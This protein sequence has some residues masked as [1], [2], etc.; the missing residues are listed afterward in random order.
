MKKNIVIITVLGC[1]FA[2]LM[3]VGGPGQRGG[4]SGA[5]RSA[6]PQHMAPPA[7]SAPPQHIAPRAPPQHIAPR[8]PPQHVAPRAPQ[9]HIAPRAAPRQAQNFSRSPSLSRS[10]PPPAHRTF[11]PQTQRPPA[12]I[13]PHNVQARQDIRNNFQQRNQPLSNLPSSLQPPV[14]FPTST[15]Q[16]RQ[17]ISRQADGARSQ[18]NRRYPNR[19]DWFTDNFFKRHNYHPYYN[20]PGANWWWAP[21]WGNVCSWLPWGWTTPY[22]Y[23]DSGSYYSVPQQDYQ[24][25]PSSYATPPQESDWM[26]LGVFAAGHTAQEAA[27]STMVVQLALN[28]EGFI[29]GTYYNTATNEVHDIDGAVDQYTQEAAWKISD[30]PNSPTMSTG[31]YN[32]TQD[33]AIIEVVFPDGTRQNWTYVRMQK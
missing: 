25:E 26:A 9:Q 31:L 2:L 32:L 6:P 24:Q 16:Q 7:R 1:S 21:Y 22:Y 12:T 4:G 30:D 11:T 10:V 28:Q 20:Y 15:Q 17:V 23:D 29:A 14:Q 33:A 13:G 27:Y 19:S 5:P 18:L 3:A 8:P